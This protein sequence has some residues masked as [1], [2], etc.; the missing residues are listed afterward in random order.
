MTHQAETIEISCA[1]DMLLTEEM[2]DFIKTRYEK[3]LAGELNLVKVSAPVVVPD[4]TGINDDLDGLEKPISFPVK[5]L[6]GQKASIIQSLAKWKRMRLRYYHIGP[7]KGILTDMRALRPN[8]TLTPIHSVYVDQWDWE[9]NIKSEERSLKLLKSTVESIYG[10]FR[11]IEAELC[12]KYSF[13]TPQ[14]PEKIKFI[15]AQDLL[16]EY[17]DLSPKEREARA[18]KMY[19]AIFIIGIGHALSNG[20]PHDGRAPDYDDWSTLNDDGYYGLNGDI[21]FWNPALE[22]AFEISSMG[23]RV[24]RKSMERQLEISGCQDRRDLLFHSLLLEGQLPLSIGG[25]IG[26]SRLCMYLLKKHHIGEVQSSI[27]PADVITQYMGKDVKL[28]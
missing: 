26:Q 9:K 14:L 20:E 19:G 12:E 6:N 7:G 10:T 13:V 16:D 18:A 15:H 25:G 17:P 27:W 11:Q 28:L 24:D 3:L 22:S 5:S 21:I 4:G 1:N 2:I 8:E 23:I